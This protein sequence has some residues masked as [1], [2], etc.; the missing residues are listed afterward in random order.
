MLLLYAISSHGCEFL[1]VTQ[2]LALT[3]GEKFPG[4]LLQGRSL[5]LLS[6]NWWPVIRSE[7]SMEWQ[8]E[9][10]KEHKKVKFE[11]GIKTRKSKT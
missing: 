2:S 5:A 7:K 8:T 10:L 11:L 1:P 9:D 3:S 4:D 6:L